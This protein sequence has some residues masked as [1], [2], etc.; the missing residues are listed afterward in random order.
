[1]E[2]TVPVSFLS[3]A[4]INSLSLPFL[5]LSFLHLSLS[6]E[7]TNPK[8]KQKTKTIDSIYTTN[9]TSLQSPSPFSNPSIIISQFHPLSFSFREER[10]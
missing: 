10:K 8:K 6:K 9:S 5:S 1:L 4:Y 3:L 7:E 2:E